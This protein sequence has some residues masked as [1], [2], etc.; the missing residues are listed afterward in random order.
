MEPITEIVELGVSIGKEQTFG[1]IARGCTAAQA[2]YIRQMKQSES[3]KILGLTWDQ[4]CPKYLGISRV[5]ADEI[6]HRLETLGKDFFRLREFMRISPKVY[7]RIQPAVKGESIEINGE[8]V[9]IT[10]D[11]SA[12]IRAAVLKIRSELT[13][14][15]ELAGFHASEYVITMQ[16]RLGH[17]L[18]NLYALAKRNYAKPEEIDMVAAIA[19]SSIEK[20]TE[21]IEVCGRRR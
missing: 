20:L 1:L 15:T 7:R 10:P 17:F 4:Y 19:R 16:H 2:E 18:G 11:N 12:R 3:Y 21:I 5:T 8:M 6:V 9:P 14:A 13:A